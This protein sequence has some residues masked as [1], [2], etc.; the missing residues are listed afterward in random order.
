MTASKNK[1]P[2]LQGWPELV[3]RHPVETTEALSGFLFEA[4]ASALRQDEA[5]AG[6]M[7]TVAGFPAGPPPSGLA[8][9]IETFVT[10]LVTIFNLPRSPRAEWRLT[11]PA[12]WAEKWKEG[13]EPLEI[14][15]GL[16]IK[17]SW[18]EYRA[19]PGRKVIT[20]DPGLAFGTG[21]HASTFLCLTILV[22]VLSRPA[23]VDGRILDLGTGS[24]I[25]ALAAAALGGRTVVAL[26]NDIEVMPVAAANL[27]A[28]GQTGRIRLIA[29]EPSALRG[30]FNLILANLTS[31]ELIRQAEEI[32]RLSVPGTILAASGLLSDQTRQIVGHYGG[33][34]F[35]PRET[36]SRDEWAALVLERKQ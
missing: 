35:E 9:K 33:L 29:G 28:N 36:L 16:A 8:K 23:M 30:P 14:G 24:G 13:L 7:T 2:P 32:E 3:I 27:A 17:P 26:D 21:Y 25:L 4:G 19:G 34:G 5:S 6:W 10:E 12:D 15:E 11:P 1:I 22:G 31:G 20:L 18:C